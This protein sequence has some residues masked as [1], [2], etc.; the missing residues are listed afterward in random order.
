MNEHLHHVLTLQEL[1]V[2][3]SA[4]KAVQVGFFDP[5]IDIDSI[6]YILRDISEDVLRHLDIDLTIFPI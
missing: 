3:C 2:S 1:D 4:N 5:K 6:Q